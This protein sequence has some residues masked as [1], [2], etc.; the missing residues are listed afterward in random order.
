MTA[1]V[2]CLIVT[3]FAPAQSIALPSV[4]MT[5]QFERLGILM[6]S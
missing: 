1:T 5:D 3:L 6:P 4:R 2:A